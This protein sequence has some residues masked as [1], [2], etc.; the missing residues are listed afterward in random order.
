MN[1]RNDKLIGVLFSS[2]TL[3]IYIC[4]CIQFMQFFHVRDNM[5]NE[6]Q[7]RYQSQYN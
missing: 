6:P 3:E 4:S 2:C 7:N 1:Y 5:A